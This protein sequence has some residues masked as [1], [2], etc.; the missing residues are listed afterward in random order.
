MNHDNKTVKKILI[1]KLAAIGD[2][3][4]AS[5]LISNLKHNY[6][7][8]RIDW[9][10]D[11]WTELVLKHM[12][13]LDN[14]FFF[15]RPWL[16]K[17]KIK[18]YLAVFSLLRR[19]RREHYDLAIIPHRSDLA[20]RLA[21]NARIKKKVGF[22]DESNNNLDVAVS[23]DSSKHEIER[24][25]DL[26][27]AI[28]LKV[29][30]RKMIFEVDKKVHEDTINNFLSNVNGKYVSISPGGGKNPGLDM[31][32]KRWDADNYIELIN[33]LSTLG[34]E[35]V[36]VGTDSDK[37]ICDYV[38]KKTDA[39]NLCSKTDL[40]QAAAIIKGSALYIGNDS[41][42]LYIASAVG[43]PTLGLYGPTDPRL[44]APLES[45]SDYAISKSQCS[46]CYH[47]QSTKQG[48]YS[49]CE[50]DKRCMKDLEV[51]PVL[52]KASK[53]LKNGQD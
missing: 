49:K 24:N 27:R 29:E 13:Q 53:L 12:P 21:K 47:P 2:V 37:E 15:D 51:E 20:F 17:S 36:L 42:P 26:L 25:L 16:Q 33:G 8:A 1:I 30:D 10:A 5:P 22:A 46:P 11:S 50:Y 52:E 7:D 6:P 18:G 28:G 38:S 48:D 14:V 44:L 4:F 3:M 40:S 41:G 23:Y 45:T 43:A 9:L 32:L 34:N 19:L 35:A 31:P 39:I